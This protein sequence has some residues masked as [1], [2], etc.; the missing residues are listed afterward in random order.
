MSATAG[1][2][3]DSD[4]IAGAGGANWDG[5]VHTPTTYVISG[6][7]GSYNNGATAFNLFLDALASVGNGVQVRISYDFTGN[8]SNDRLETYNYYAT[9]DVTGYEDYNHIKGLRSTTGSFANLSNG[10][11]RVEIGSAIGNGSSVVRTDA[12]TAQGS[13]SR[14]VVPF[15]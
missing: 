14:I 3:A 6:V 1:S 5:N 15:S 2:N 4:A 12:T 10:K 11:V 13:Q 7:S 9:N 8:G